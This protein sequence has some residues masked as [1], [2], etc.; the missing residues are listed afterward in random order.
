M[1]FYN[2]TWSNFLVTLSD[3]KFLDQNYFEENITFCFP[4]ISYN[5]FLVSFG[6]N[7]EPMGKIEKQSVGVWCFRHLFCFAKCRSKLLRKNNNLSDINQLNTVNTKWIYVV[8]FGEHDNNVMNWYLLSNVRKNPWA[9]HNVSPSFHP[10][11]IAAVKFTGIPNSAMIS[12]ANIIFINSVVNSSC[13]CN[14]WVNMG[15]VA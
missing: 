5:T 2:V 12:S 9:W 3:E 8:F 6:Y 14:D 7:M 15:V 1:S 10:C 13:S 4:L 11:W